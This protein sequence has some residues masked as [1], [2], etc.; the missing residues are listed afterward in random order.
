M[1]DDVDHSSTLLHTFHLSRQIGHLHTRIKD[2]QAA[3]E[4]VDKRLKDVEQQSIALAQGLEAKLAER[5]EDHGAITDA[6]SARLSTLETSVESIDSKNTTIN[7]ALDQIKTALKTLEAQ[8][9][10]EQPAKENADVLRRLNVVEAARQ[11]HDLEASLTE[12]RLKHLEA[13]NYKLRTA[14]D[15]VTA[16]MQTQWT[17]RQPEQARLPPNVTPVFPSSPPGLPVLSSSPSPKGP[18]FISKTLVSK[19]L[20]EPKRAAPKRDAPKQALLPNKKTKMARELEAIRD[21][22]EFC[23]TQQFVPETMLV[24]DVSQAPS[25]VGP[26]MMLRSGRNIVKPSQANANPKSLLRKATQPRKTQ[27]QDSQLRY[28]HLRKSQPQEIPSQEIPTRSIKLPPPKSNRTKRPRAKARLL[29]SVASQFRVSKASPAPKSSLPQVPSAIK[30]PPVEP[31]VLK[32]T[33]PKIWRSGQAAALAEIKPPS[34]TFNVVGGIHSRS[35]YKSFKNQAVEIAS[36]VTHS[37]PE[38]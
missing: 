9:K 32:S 14:L 24:D 31:S 34:V 30:L 5:P 19:A 10:Q 12:R 36:S 6:L 15:E 11:G 25:A 23:D 2:L 20:P 38:L 8:W 27:V 28:I 18:S 21:T 35:G 7:R 13:E 37:E 3:R 22:Q 33:G 26:K 16:K 4:T 29:G 1:A 17:P